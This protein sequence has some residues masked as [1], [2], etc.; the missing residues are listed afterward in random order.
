MSVASV[1]QT[2][3]N[4]RM[5]QPARRYLLT[6]RTAPTPAPML[7]P[8]PQL[9]VIADTNTLAARAC[10]TVRLGGPE[11]L[12]RGL[13]M[14]GRSRTFV[15]AHV[16]LEL[17]RRLPVIAA[18]SGVDVAAAQA[19]LRSEVMSGVLAVRLDIRDCLDPRIRPILRDD[20]GWVRG[21]RRGCR[22]HG[23][24]RRTIAVPHG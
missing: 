4:L 3:H 1:T 10:N 12:F 23:R 8:W 9:V 16:P 13:A 18:S 24:A 7:P 6:S 21:E 5:S 11:S 15:G 20:L 2:L 14:T 22:A 17:E 19:V